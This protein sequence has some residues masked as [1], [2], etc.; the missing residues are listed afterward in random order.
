MDKKP[1]GF[2]SFNIID[3][4]D[5]TGV[6][7]GLQDG[8]VPLEDLS[9][10]VEL[11]TSLKSRSLLI[12]STEGTSRVNSEG[13]IK[14]SFIN[15][16]KK[17]KNKLST[18][19][20]D[21][22]DVTTDGDIE[23]TLGITNI[24][25]SFDTSYAPKITINFVDVRGAGIFQNGGKSKYAV[26]F[27]MPYP[28]FNL[29]IKGFY[30]K[31]VRYC[32]HLL[33]VNSKFN[34]QTGNFELV[35]EFVGYT[36]AILTD[37]L[38]GYLKAIP[39]MAEAKPYF[40][41]L[42]KTD[43]VIPIGE[44][45]KLL[46]QIDTVGVELLQTN[47]LA[48][49]LTAVL[50]LRE[51]LTQIETDITSLKSD[52]SIGNL[53]TEDRSVVIKPSVQNQA[54]LET[55]KKNIDYYKERVLKDI[56]DYNSRAN[57]VLVLDEKIF[58]NLISYYGVSRSD[59]ENE[60][61]SFKNTVRQVN[62][63]T[64]DI[65]IGKIIE[66]LRN[67]LVAT[68]TVGSTKL[69]IHDFT[70]ELTLIKDTL[71]QLYDYELSIR[72][73][74]AEAYKDLVTTKLSFEPTIR[75]IMNI[76]T[77][78][79][80]VF[81][82][83]LYDVSAKYQDKNRLK[84]LDK[85]KCT[86]RIDVNCNHEIYPWPEYN[87][88][89]NIEQYL[90]SEGVVD[91]PLDIPEVD[92]VERLY[93]AMIIAF[94]EDKEAETTDLINSEFIWYAVNPLDTKIANPKAVSPYKRISSPA[95]PE[96]IAA[97]ALIRAIT[98]LSIS[99]RGLSKTEI[100]NMAVVEANRVFETFDG[101]NDT[102][103]QV[104]NHNWDTD[105]I[106][107]TSVRFKDSSND[108]PIMIKFGDDWE[109]N[110][111]HRKEKKYIPVLHGF[112][113]PFVTPYEENPTELN[114]L[115]NY[116]AAFDTNLIKDYDVGTYVKFYTN[117]Q[118]NNAAGSVAAPN[119]QVTTNGLNYGELLVGLD[120]KN[121]SK[122]GFNPFSQTHGTQVYREVDW[123]EE[124]Y[125]LESRFLFYANNT[126]GS[127]LSSNRIKNSIEFDISANTIEIN[128]I[129]TSFIVDNH[130][131]AYTNRN[132]YG[133]NYEIAD[134][135]DINLMAWPC[136]NFGVF[137]QYGLLT[138]QRIFGITKYTDYALFGSR[139]FYEQTNMGKALL[140]LHTF[141]W[142]GVAISP[143]NPNSRNK[144]VFSVSINGYSRNNGVFSVP[145]IINQLAYRAGLVQVPKLWPAF[146]GGLLYRYENDEIIKFDNGF[147]NF[148]PECNLTSSMPKR[149]EYLTVS[150]DNP[151][152]L[153]FTPLLESD[154]Y[155]KL[156]EVLLNLPK[157]VKKSFKDE[158]IQ[159]V[160][161][162]WKEINGLLQLMPEGSTADDWSSK[163]NAIMNETFIKKTNKGDVLSIKLDSIKSRFVNIDN[164]ISVVPVKN[165]THYYNPTHNFELEL[166]DGSPA[167][168]RII[169]EF[170]ATKWMLN[171]Q[172]A[173]WALPN[174]NINSDGALATTQ[175]NKIIIKNDDLNTY[176]NKFK[177]TL[178]TLKTQPK[179]NIAKQ[180]LGINEND[181]IKLNIYRTLKAIYDKWI[182]GTDSPESILFQCGDRLPGDKNLAKKRGSNTTRF[183]DS[184]RFISRAFQDIGDDFYVNPR[185]LKNLL[186]GKLNLSM[187]SLIS[188][189]LK[190]NNFDFVALPS[191]INYHDGKEL[192]SVFKPYPYA[193]AVDLAVTGPSFVCV[194]VGQTSTKLDFNDGLNET[195]PHPND[196][197]DIDKP[198]AD[199][200]NTREEWEETGAA[201]KVDYAKQNQNV[202]TDLSLDQS[203]F[204]ETSELLENTES[205]ANSATMGAKSYVGQS[206]YNVWSVRSYRAQV[207]MLGNAMIQPMMYFQ[208]NSVP[209][210]HGAYLITSVKHN[211]KPGFMKTSFAGQRIKNVATPLIED[212][213]LFSSLLSDFKPASIETSYKLSDDRKLVPVRGNNEKYIGYVTR[214]VKEND[215]LIYQTKNAGGDNYAIKEVGDFMELLAVR[216]YNKAKNELYTDK[217]Y[218]N[219]FSGYKGRSHKL[220]RKNSKHGIG[221]AVDFRPLAKDKTVGR[222]TVGSDRY[223]REANKEFI[224]FA[225]DLI[226]TNGNGLEFDNIILNDN[227]LISEITD[228]NSDNKNI[229]IS[230]PG[231]PDHIHFEF[232]MPDRIVKRVQE[233]YLSED[234][235]KTEP[236]LGSAVAYS[237]NKPI[238]E[239]IKQYLGQV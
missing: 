3:P 119:V 115:T 77:S 44:L 201:F 78:H 125:S 88:E 25:I 36:Y 161:N 177:T 13:D 232:N 23:E 111:Q 155:K 84:Q 113:E 2:N 14:I 102:N 93:Q 220:D 238:G 62:N 165:D 221:L 5:Y 158:F 219:N 200:N 65:Q 15:G 28:I 159:F 91:R 160:N 42:K 199:F 81:I 202:F 227:Q 74:L 123:G 95:R 120:K 194:Y 237:Q 40:D 83:I 198:P 222:V 181:D 230:Y 217:L 132:Y 121:I 208:L 82:K 127:G 8:F 48:K 34:S 107:S 188:E 55:Q 231:H 178:Q 224:R 184:F 100:E 144:T 39:E 206:L 89:Y 130:I 12:S 87:N 213:A 239:N 164:Y 10:S 46:G 109:Y 204:S 59:V 103:L 210:F 19:Y 195:Y 124:K 183:I 80:E 190:E 56:K 118:F 114:V 162:D 50:E 27:K 94:K 182:S 135:N 163:Y 229:L 66:R 131:V 152:P 116:N 143:I 149:D 61:T 157:S 53:L 133:K 236:E 171:S 58:I 156:D 228:K 9:I 192:T 41:E 63:I 137:E 203:E 99:N 226:K 98:Y 172:W 106:K 211:I 117:D 129:K 22:Y 38:I 37:M 24:D 147:D 1:T 140:F 214:E 30:G 209:M 145:R 141:P 134:K 79:V 169:T 18:T 235:I 154:S 187:Y 64:D 215:G 197:F 16:N 85:F 52:L 75:N 76:L 57:G 173:I 86:Q 17:D 54:D 33:K 69:D 20:T 139:F 108:I 90:G 31:P 73:E 105:R 170:L 7:G 112:S 97:T 128:V 191:F 126:R 45:I 153:S 189:I 29:T 175:Y 32:L 110:Y 60:T 136:I 6:N 72:K 96:K 176:F 166:K 26:L 122:I 168:Q 150:D 148:I 233:G 179:V 218:V 205:I 21:V 35:A 185:I 11:T 142:N 68:D 101:D 216:W 225:L 47:P 67:K 212:S 51:K 223:D 92:F 151:Y 104:F 49:D 4:N 43:N 196:G 234:N 174:D 180:G 71:R 138:D 193:E 207:E 186:I 167:M 146:I 70:T